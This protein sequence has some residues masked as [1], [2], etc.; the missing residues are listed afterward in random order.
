MNPFK[1][2]RSEAAKLRGELRAAGISLDH[3]ALDLVVAACRHLD[4][5]LKKAKPGE[6]VKLG[7]MRDGQRIELEATLAEPKR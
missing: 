5:K 4:V 7:V 2:A 6:K 3:P 1:A